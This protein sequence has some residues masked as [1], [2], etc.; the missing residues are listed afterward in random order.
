MHKLDVFGLHTC[1]VCLFVDM[2]MSVPM[3]RYMSILLLVFECAFFFFVHTVVVCFYN[4]IV[5]VGNA[6][7]C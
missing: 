6:G 4:Q 7:S 1:V 3:L 5:F 2:T